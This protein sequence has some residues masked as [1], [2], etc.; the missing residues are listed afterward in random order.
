[1]PRTHTS[2]QYAAELRQ[3]RES[4]LR[5]AGYV[6][7]MIADSCRA[8]VEGNIELAEKTIE[9]D[10]I[11]NVLEVE[12]DELC[13]LILAKRQPL[14]SDLRMITLAMK[15]VTDLERIGDLATNISERV[16]A[17]RTVPK[18]TVSD[19]IK[20]MSDIVQRMIQACLDAFMSRDVSKAREVFAVDQ[21]VDDLYRELTD[22]VQ[23]TMFENRNYVEVG[24]HLNAVAK[25]LERIG[26]HSTN[27]AELVIF[28]VD[29]E[30]IRHKAS[31]FR[32]EQTKS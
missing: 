25:F 12:I 31:R 21:D 6:E 24:V 20:R 3:V 13:L 14:A 29:G 30:D 26:D 8:L 28:L 19:R 27:L 17:L 11:V 7:R 2:R 15:M 18:P 22:D 23:A 32:Q 16:L 9:S 10:T 4:L 5:M 1:M